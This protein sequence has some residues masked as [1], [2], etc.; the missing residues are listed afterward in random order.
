MRVM[1][2][3]GWVHGRHKDVREEIKYRRELGVP[4][5]FLPHDLLHMLLPA[6]KLQVGNVYVP[7]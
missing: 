3:G 4:E 7:M 1:L 2:W 6:K 5:T